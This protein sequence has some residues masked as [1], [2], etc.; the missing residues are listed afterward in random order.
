MKK[1]TTDDFK[2]EMRLNSWILVVVAIIMLILFLSA[3]GY[4]FNL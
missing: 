3:A 1:A 4:L 2:K